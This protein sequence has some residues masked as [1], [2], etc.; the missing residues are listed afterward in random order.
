MNIKPVLYLFT[1]S[2]SSLF[3][4]N[5][6]YAAPLTL[7]ERVAILENQL[8][9]NMKELDATKAQLKKY[10]SANL[11]TTAR[12]ET[13]SVSV[14]T[15]D[16]ASMTL[17][18]ISKYVKED[19]GFN[20]SGYFRSGYAAGNRGAAKSYAIGSLGRFGQ[21][22]SSWYDLE[23]SQR[24]YHDGI[25]TAKA[26]V[27]LDGNVGGQYSAGWFDRTSDNLLQFSDI[28]LTTR[29]FLPF[30]PE[31]D[32]WVGKH[33]LPKFEIQML[34]FKYHKSDS[35]AGIGLENWQLGPGKVNVALVREDLDAHA[36]DSSMDQ[37]QQINTNTVDARYTGM[38]LWNKATL[39][40][41]GRYS[42][43]NKTDQNKRDENN[44][45]YYSVKDA[46]HAGAR[47]TQNWQNGGFTYLTAQMA[48][49]SIAS[50]M[51]LVTDSSAL[52]GYNGQYYGEHT[53]GTA[54]RVLSEGENYL[55]PNVV[56]A[57]ALVYAAGNDIYDY[58]TGA[59]TDF[60]STRAVMRPAYIWDTF[61]QTGVELGWFDQRNKADGE[62]YRE[63]GLKMTLFH[64]LKVGPSML[65]SRPEIR[66][67]ATYL[68]SFDNEI[69]Q[70]TF[71]D[72]KKDQFTVGA[73]AEVWW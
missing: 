39:D 9:S 28:Y 19:I 6:L 15:S 38:P 58:Y 65:T 30:A 13:K 22:N 44:G 26:V 60:H 21:E 61:N 59:H 52:Y 71:N 68:K 17:A 51:G 12:N 72:D 34:D 32:F 48:N 63:S 40:L 64:T 10:E 20:Y 4:A 23:L 42:A 2:A 49:N 1:L 57:H 54:W 41:F 5:A 55:L 3:V 18:D 8:S 66:F 24:V 14:I 53:N 31:A 43:A 16:V 36:I 25:K 37:T 47:L 11:P 69:T 27:M 35:A 62:S 73:Q 45:T 70:F 50:G 33:T 29:G 46:W 7:E 56:I 67:F